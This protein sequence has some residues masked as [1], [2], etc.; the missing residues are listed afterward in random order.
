MLYAFSF[1]SNAS[2]NFTHTIQ[3]TSYR[4][5]LVYDLYTDSYYMHIDKLSNGAFVRLIQ[6]VRVTTGINLLLQYSYLNLGGIWV[7][8]V[9]DET[10]RQIP[11]AA[12]INNGFIFTWEHD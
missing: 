9:G 11:G 3:G 6:G 1:K 5:H 8:P 2:Y 7:L 10:I 12:T 4:V